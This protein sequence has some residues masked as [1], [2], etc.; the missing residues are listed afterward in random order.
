MRRKRGGAWEGE[1]GD[2][3]VEERCLTNRGIEWVWGRE[4]QDEL[5]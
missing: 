4:W 1:S 2:L 5:R 3:E